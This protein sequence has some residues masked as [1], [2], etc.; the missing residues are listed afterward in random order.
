MSTDWINRLTKHF[1]LISRLLK[2][3]TLSIFAR[4]LI[5]FMGGKS[6]WRS[7]L[8]FFHSCQLV[9]IIPIISVKIRFIHMWQKTLSN[10]GLNTLVLFHHIKNFKVGSKS[11]ECLESS[12]FQLSAAIARVCRSSSWFKITAKTPAIIPAFQ[13]TKLRKRCCRTHTLPLRTSQKLHIIIQ[14]TV[15]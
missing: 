12:F 3:L 14:N 5:A 13:E 7:L 6:F 11:L 15:T 9:A 4:F 1:L 8:W 10:S 2:K